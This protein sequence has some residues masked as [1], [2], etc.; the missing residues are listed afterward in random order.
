ML[1]DIEIIFISGQSDFESLMPISF[2]NETEVH[3]FTSN[4]ETT[5]EY[6]DSVILTFTPDNPALIPG[7]E[8]QGEYVRDTV[9][10]QIIDSDSKCCFTVYWQHLVCFLIT[11]L[12]INFEESDYSI[13]E[14]GTLSTDIRFHFRNNQNPFSV[15]LCPVDMDTVEALGLGRF[16]NSE[17]I[18]IISRA[19]A[20]EW[21]YIVCIGLCTINHLHT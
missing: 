21:I 20:G 8:A 12:E 15:R 6:D 18:D 4:D 1:T 10:V 7:L 19:T 14:R 3:L 17:E 16:I 11:G 2:V 9:T 13:E 5:L